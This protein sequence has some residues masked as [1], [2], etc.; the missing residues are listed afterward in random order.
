[1]N[2]LSYKLC[3]CGCLREKRRGE[4]LEWDIFGKHFTSQKER[5]RRDEG[6]DG[7]HGQEGTEKEEESG[8]K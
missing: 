7:T 5:Q 8:T 6:A 1:M 4:S 3:L 2:I